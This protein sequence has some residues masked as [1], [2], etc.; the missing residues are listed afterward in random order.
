MSIVALQSVIVVGLLE[1][2]GEVIESLQDLGCLHLRSL[3]PEEAMRIQGDNLSAETRQAW[4][5]LK[6]CPIQRQRIDNSARYEPS[7]M[8]GRALEIQSRIDELADQQDFLRRR[9]EDVQAWGEFHFAPLKEM[10]GFRFWFYVVPLF[11]LPEVEALDLTY[12]VVRRDN[13]FAYVVVIAR[14]EPEGMPVERVLF[15]SRSLSELRHQLEAV[16]LE[17]DDLQME[18]EGLTRGLSIYERNMHRLEDITARSQAEKLTHD[19]GPLFALQ[20]WVPT[21]RAEEVKSLAERRELALVV[22]DPE[23]DEEPPTLLENPERWQIGESLVGFYMTPGYRLWDPSLVVLFSFTLFFAMIISDAGYGLLMALGLMVFGKK[24]KATPGGRRVRVLFQLLS[25]ATIVWGVLV[26]S[27]FGLSPQPDSLPGALKKIDMNDMDSMMTLSIL[28]GAFHVILANSMDA[29]RQRQS[30]AAIAPV[31]WIVAILGGLLLWRGSG[32]ETG[33]VMETLGA[34]FLGIG[35]V[36]VFVFSGAG[37]G[38]GVGGRIATGLMSLTKIT[39]AFG[40]ILSYLRLFALGLASASLAV[41]FNGL[42]RDAHDSIPGFGFLLA[43]IVIVVGH[44]LNFVLA[45]VSGFVHGLR[46]N[47]I[48]FFNWSVPEEGTPFRVFRKNETWYET[49]A[50]D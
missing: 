33:E 43:I 12:E 13:R 39:N 22:R 36:A 19:S 34:A 21:E 9:I 31:G 46:L 29:W 4:R 40:D 37:S 16:E 8:Q 42:A 18:R 38:K 45:I 6:D 20:A 41:A 17:L 10:E 35:L 28:I 1:E 14:T 2:K 49:Q 32:A 44:T 26:G 48:E 27:Y 3:R 11:Q 47:L 25:G 24:L 23:P 7:Y 5:F 50:T 15:G 30:A